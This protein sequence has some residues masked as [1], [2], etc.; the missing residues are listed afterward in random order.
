M[1]HLMASN[2]LR[3]ISCRN[4]KNYGDH[5]WS[6]ILSCHLF[7]GRAHVVIK[8]STS[9]VFFNVDGVQMSILSYVAR[10]CDCL[11]ETSSLAVVL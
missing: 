1:L 6:F 9:V 8:S 4:L 7:Y 2:G 5:H 3:Q 11:V 10:G